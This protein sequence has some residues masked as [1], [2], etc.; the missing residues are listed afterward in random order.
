MDEVFL[1][2][3]QALG[4]EREVGAVLGE[5]GQARVRHAEQR[6]AGVAG[7]IAQVLAHLGRA[8]RAVQADHVD[9]EG[10]QRGERGADLGAEQHGA[11]G[12]EGHGD[13][14]GYVDAGRLHGAA[15]AQ[16]RRLGLQEVL[17]GLHDQ[18]VG[19]TGEQAL[20]VGLE[21]VAEGA[22]AD[23]AEGGQLGAG[24]DGAED[25][26]LAAVAGGEVVGGLAGD[27]GAG[28]GEF[29][30]ALGDVVLGH[31]GVVRA[32]GVRLDAVHADAEVLLVDRA[33][34]VG[35]G[36]VQDLVAAFEVLEVVERGVLRLE[37]GAHGSVGDH[38]AGGECLS[39]R[40]HPGPAVG[41]RGRWRRGHEG[42]PWSATAVG[43]AAS[44][45]TSHG[46]PRERARRQGNGAGREDA[47]GV[48]E[49]DLSDGDA[50]EG[51]RDA[52]RGDVRVNAV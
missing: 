46:T 5:D 34:D 40:G 14:Q 25:P 30:D 27:A 43:F 42:A 52:D 20:G 1:R 50:Y 22:V 12:L 33:D 6:G 47:R 17:G 19:A 32:E 2:V 45:G 4:V 48:H 37:H 31:R 11:S 9:A 8:R 35:A 7:E 38:H 16:D 51:E 23:V 26:A 41:R 36:D 13:Q 21:A 28:L 49:A 24:A 44:Q 18:G 3:G 29:V 39:E 15:G 10:F